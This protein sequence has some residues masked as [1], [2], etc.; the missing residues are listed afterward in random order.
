MCWHCIKTLEFVFLSLFMPQKNISL[1]LQ[2]LKCFLKLCC[3]VFS[4]LKVVL[5]NKYNQKKPCF[6]FLSLVKQQWNISIN[7]W[8]FVSFLKWMCPTKMLFKSF[9]DFNNI[10]AS[11]CL[12]FII[13]LNKQLRFS[14][15]SCVHGSLAC[16]CPNPRLG[17]K[18]QRPDYQ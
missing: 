3:L 2:N 11:T 10:K 1:K 6:L 17:L 4:F 9:V 12:L 15:I 5:I 14:K 13:L 18:H 8:H 7:F 16:Y